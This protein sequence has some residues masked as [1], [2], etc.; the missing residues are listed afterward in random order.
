[1]C[2][3]TICSVIQMAT[4]D[5]GQRARK[6][7]KPLKIPKFM[8]FTPSKLYSFAGKSGQSPFGDDNSCAIRSKAKNIIG[9]DE[10]L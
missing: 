8:D 9:D 6:D 5:S 3:F 1:M 4:T 2:H 7:G 10:I